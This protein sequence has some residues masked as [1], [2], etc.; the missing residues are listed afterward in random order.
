MSNQTKGGFMNTLDTIRTLINQ[1]VSLENRV[2]VTKCFEYMFDISNW[3][4]YWWIDY[5]NGDDIIKSSFDDKELFF[6]VLFNQ[7]DLIYN[8]NLESEQFHVFFKAGVTPFSRYSPG[9][10]WCLYATC[11]FEKDMQYLQDDKKEDVKKIFRLFWIPSQP[12]VN[13]Y[14][15]VLE[16]FKITKETVQQG[17]AKRSETAMKLA[18]QVVSGEKKINKLLKTEIVEILTVLQ[19][20]VEETHK[21][22]RKRLLGCEKDDL[23]ERLETIIRF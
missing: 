12:Q 21:Q 1:Y 16:Q 9:D 6:N 5:G 20:L 8:W 15:E 7:F 18:R 23:L 13:Y 4:F 2:E 3:S 11:S 14:L 10:N 17:I 22:R 19:P